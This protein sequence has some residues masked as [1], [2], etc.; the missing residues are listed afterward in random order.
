MVR[1]LV[2]FMIAPFIF[3]MPLSYANPFENQDVS[4]DAK[5]V[6]E[7][8]KIKFPIATAPPPQEKKKRSKWTIKGEIDGKFLL[9]DETGQKVIK[10]ENETIEGCI[11]K[12]EG[13]QC[14][15]E[16][17]NTARQREMDLIIQELKKK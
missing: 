1:L 4:A 7:L 9:I 15:P 16:V 13:I 8:E 5:S 6:Q 11:V 14:E 17:D 2:F 12:R 3:F 10:K